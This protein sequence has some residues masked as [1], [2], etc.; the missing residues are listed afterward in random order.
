MLPLHQSTSTTQSHHLPRGRPREV[1]GRHE[2]HG[3]GQQAQRPRHPGA[4][5]LPAARAHV[6]RGAHEPVEQAGDGPAHGHEAQLALQDHHHREGQPHRGRNGVWVHVDVPAQVL[7]GKHLRALP[8]DVVAGDAKGKRTEEPHGDAPAVGPHDVVL[9]PHARVRGRDD[10]VRGDAEQVEAEA[11]REPPAAHEDLGPLG[12]L[13]QAGTERHDMRHIATM[14][15][16]PA[17]SDTY[18]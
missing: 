14:T 12:P 11:P 15:E 3:G 5:A 7:Y 9:A 17:S 6:R 1:H 4:E 2:G 18:E 13:G 8:E 10:A 16:V